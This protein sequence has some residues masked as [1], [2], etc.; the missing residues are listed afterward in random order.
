M[1]NRSGR[2]TRRETGDPTEVLLVEDTPGDARL[3][4]EAFTSIDSEATL[5]TVTEGEEAIDV[6]KQRRNGESASLPEL[7]L[8]DLNLPGVDGCDVL[9]LIRADSQLQSLP[10]IMLTSSK[11]ADDVRRCYDAHANAYLTKPTD[12]DEFVSLVETL[13]RF[14]FEY[15]RLP[16][17]PQ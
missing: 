4:Q 6:L 3:V 11:A 15:A 16:P 14:W 9:E 1:R 10:V 12:L 17:I 2:S 5:H 7:V 13:E 8:V